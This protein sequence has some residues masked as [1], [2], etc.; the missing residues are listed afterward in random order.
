MSGTPDDLDHLFVR[1][2]AFIQS[3]GEI[4]DDPEESVGHSH[5]AEADRLGAGR[6]SDQIPAQFV[7]HADLG[8][9][10]VSGS[11]ETDID[12]LGLHVQTECIGGGLQMDPTTERIR[13][14]DV[15][16]LPV[17][18]GEVAEGEVQE[19]GANGEAAHG[20]IGPQ[21]SDGSGGECGL[22][23]SHLGGPRDG[24]IVHL[25][26]WIFVPG[27]VALH[28][29]NP[30]TLVDAFGSPNQAEFGWHGHAGPAKGRQTFPNT[31]A[32]DQDDI[33]FPHDC[34]ATRLLRPAY[35]KPKLSDMSTL[36]E[37]RPNDLYELLDLA[38][39]DGSVE[40]EEYL[41]R[42]VEKALDWF[43]A[44]G[45][46][47]FLR[48]GGTETF[49]LAVAHGLLSTVPSDAVI[50]D[51]QGIAGV[52]I[53][54]GQPRLLIDPTSD[55][56]LARQGIERKETIGSS[57]IIPLMTRNAGCIGVMNVARAAESADF[58]E[59]DLEA[60]SSL[61]RQIALALSQYRTLVA[62]QTQK[63]ELQSAMDLIGFGLLMIGPGGRFQDFTPEIA[64]IL[65]SSPRNHLTV[66]T[67]FQTINPN[68][69]RPLNLGIE[70]AKKNL[71]YRF[72]VDDPI[73]HVTYAA[74]T[75]PM[76]NGGV[77]VAIHDITEHEKAR[78]AID[79]I[80]R[81]AE[82][83][84]LTASIAHEIRNPLTG[85]QSAARMII[86]DPMLAPEFGEIIEREAGKLNQLCT[87]FLTFAKPLS[88]DFEPI[89]LS[90][91]GRRVV[92]SMKQEFHD[93]RLRVEFRISPD[94]PILYADPIRVEQVFRNLLKNAIDA[95]SPGQLICLEIDEQG[96][97]KIRDQGIGM[98]PHIVDRLFTPFF[99][100][101][102]N[103]TGL[104]LSICHK[105]MEA[106]RSTIR[107]NSVA[108]SGTTFE[109]NFNVKGAA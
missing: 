48:N 92:D 77:I 3:A 18:H 63:Y 102:P 51:G 50:S 68:F 12:G 73:R 22:S 86:D 42:V 28:D 7:H 72:R 95:S 99:T 8:W 52:A 65:E 84:Q 38:H 36:R 71:S 35:F 55:R 64:T 59:S 56:D 62:A 105:I 33:T 45:I 89:R 107:V 104:G 39:S 13:K 10:F 1:E 91:I 79:R 19:V 88:L 11:I 17:V 34:D 24:P 43:S 32:A 9:R 26:G 44:Q 78:G 54:E 98:E 70:R 23:P 106:H 96:I 90:D 94:E 109:L 61:G 25:V 57:L 93:E 60:A 80:Q 82:I 2:G 4:R 69:Q 21:T 5:L 66:A 40:L 87:E 83:G 27:T 67:Y 58:S 31:G 37:A 46:S 85:I 81:L 6:H 100:T 97:A 20:P 41:Q 15:A 101:K 30:P 47:I 103:G 74:V 49:G 76:Q 108:G 16:H 14:I 75:A 53:A 29:H